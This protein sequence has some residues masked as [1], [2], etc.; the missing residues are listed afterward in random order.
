MALIG[1]QE[2]RP[3]SS[4]QAVFSAV[5]GCVEGT[6]RV[7]YD[8]EL[9]D[10]ALDFDDGE[11]YPFG[12]QS[13][14]Q[15]SLTAL[16][17]DIA[18]RCVQL[19]PHL[20]G[21][22]PKVINGVVL[23]DELDLHLHPKWQRRIVG[24]LNSLFPKLQFVATTHSPFIVQSLD[25]QGLINL[26]HRG[27]LEKPKEPRSVEDISEET[28]GVDRP[29]RSR[30]FHQKEAAAR[31]YYELLDRLD[32]DDHQ[33]IAKAKRELDEIEDRFMDDPAYSAFLKLQ[34]GVVE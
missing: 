23:I 27:L 5:A 3:L 8:F 15:R 24:D 26:S 20:K 17:A 9:D 11:R 2:E 1:T 29:Q 22:A 31:R 13:D 19:N 10:I 4:L 18:L 28:M 25:G 6:E 14:G 7:L 16:A 30:L 34:R 21:E 32:D 12:F 33:D